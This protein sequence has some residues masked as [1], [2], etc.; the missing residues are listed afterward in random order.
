MKIYFFVSF[1][2]F[3]YQ[4]RKE[5]VLDVFNLF[6]RNL[7]YSNTFYFAIIL[8]CIFL[9]VLG[10]SWTLRQ[11]FGTMAFHAG[12]TRRMVCPKCGKKTW[13]KKKLSK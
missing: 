13:Q 1:V 5:N 4:K 9:K 8:E 2:F 7:Y 3:K 12:R 10:T 6:E 11:Q